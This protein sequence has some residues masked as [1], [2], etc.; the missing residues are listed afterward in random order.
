MK[1]NININYAPKTKPYPHQIEA[2]AFVESNNQIA[3]FDEPGL[4]KT[5]IV[6]E[7]L[8]NNMREGLIDGALVVCKKSLIK[9]WEDEIKT[10][11][12]VSFIALRGNTNEKGLKFMGHAQF[13]II[14]YSILL[15]LK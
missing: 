1:Y 8:C 4:G 15:L 5:K 12:S 7:A 6:I 13:Y 3:L 14:N 11:S 2:I 9:N 10:H